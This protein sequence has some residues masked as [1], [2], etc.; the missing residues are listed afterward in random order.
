MTVLDAVKQSGTYLF[1]H[2]G[3][4]RAAQE[5]IAP[6]EE[7]LWAQT[8][9]VNTGSVHGELSTSYKVTD[10]DILPGVV[11]VTTRRVFFAY[12]MLGNSNYKEIRISDIRSLDSKS[13]LATEVLRIVGTTSMLVIF[14]KRK[15][16]AKLKDAINEAISRRDSDAA[17]FQH[18]SDDLLQA[19]DI[20]QLQA[21][22]QLYDSGIITA[23]E[24]A[25]K[26][27]QIL[28]L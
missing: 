26:K 28:N 15:V 1:T 4:V 17:A 13:T 21:L 8:S 12:S 25:A 11:V 7:L 19:S 23:E 24:F 16:I 10:S 18:S 9:N 20:Q 14:Q 22:K 6:T 5:M 27:A 3:S 2:K